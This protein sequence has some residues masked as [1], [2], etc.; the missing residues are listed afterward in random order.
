METLQE[1]NFTYNQSS[2]FKNSMQNVCKFC[3]KLFK[4][5]ILGVLIFCN[6]R[7]FVFSTQT[8]S[9]EFSQ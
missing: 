6:M 1:A 2:Q 9:L 3:I 8:Q 7:W 4:F 5:N